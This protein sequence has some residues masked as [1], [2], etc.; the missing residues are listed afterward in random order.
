MATRTEQLAQPKPNLLRYPNRQ[1]LYWLDKLP[2]ERAGSTTTFELTHRWAQLCRRKKSY[3]QTQIRVSPTWEVNQCALRAIPSERLCCLAQPRLPVADWQPSRPLPAALSPAVRSVVASPRICE[4]AQPKRRLGLHGSTHE[5]KTA[6][7]SCKPCKASAHIEL[8]ATPKH[9][10]PNY[11]GER[12]MSWSVSMAARN[13]VAS[14]R[15][16]ELSHPKQR[17]A[18]FEG[19]NPYIVSRAARSA[20]P[21]PRLQELSLPLPRKCTTKGWRDDIKM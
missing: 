17:K 21:S 2:P 12:S 13:A 10:H 3:P 7:V 4:L 11:L 1:S 19:Y 18:L 5:S 14:E 20:S 9:D 6:P 8:L 15:I 16:L